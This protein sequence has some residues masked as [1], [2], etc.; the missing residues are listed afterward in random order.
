MRA[1]V[2]SGT[3]ATT[4]V[5]PSRTLKIVASN[6]T[7]FTISNPTN[8]AIGERIIYDIKNSA[9]GAMGA[10]TW[11]SGGTFLLP[12]GT[13]TRPANTKRTT[14]EFYNDGTNMVALGPQS[15]D[16]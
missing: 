16:A 3:I 5:Q 11:G 1:L 13:F 14:I 6:G 12:A 10:V 8:L 7:G 2:Y 15:G 4:G 9:G